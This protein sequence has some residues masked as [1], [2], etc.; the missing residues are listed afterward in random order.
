MSTII[1]LLQ[2]QRRRCL[3]GIMGAAEST[4]FWRQSPVDE[5]RAFRSN[6]IDSLNVFYDLCR[7]ALQVSEDP[8][9]VRNERAIEVLEEAAKNIQRLLLKFPDLDA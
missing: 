4:S 7:D 8:G 6:V 9:I 2:A 1:D 3:A 5:Q